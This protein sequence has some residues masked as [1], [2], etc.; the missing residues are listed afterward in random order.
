M[1]PFYGSPVQPQALECIQLT[2]IRDGPELNELQSKTGYIDARPLLST[3]ER[4][5]SALVRDSGLP[6]VVVP[7]AQQIPIDQLPE[8]RRGT[9]SRPGDQCMIGLIVRD[10]V[11][12]RH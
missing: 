6:D 1:T 5:C 2:D 7:A 8:K 9:I 10:P 3:P 11:L 4:F 12:P